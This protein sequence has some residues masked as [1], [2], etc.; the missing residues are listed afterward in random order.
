[1]GSRV[2]TRIITGAL[3]GVA[4]LLLFSA[5]ARTPDFYNA[6][7]GVY[8]EVSREMAA[9]GQLLVPRL[10]SVP[11]LEKPPLVFWMAA[12]S[13]RLL[14]YSP[15]SGR[16]PIAVSGAL[17]VVA[18]YALVVLWE[19]ER[20][21][22]WASISLA[23]SFGYFLYARTLMLEIP[24]T[25]LFIAAMLAFFVAFKRPHYRT[26]MMLSSAALLALAVMVKG[27]IGVAMPA[28]ALCAA[29]LLSRELRAFLKTLPWL[30]MAVVFIAIAVPWHAVVETRVPGAINH[31]LV[32]GQV[33]RYVT[34]N[35]DVTTLA[36][37][38]FVAVSFVWFLPWM[39]FV[40]PAIG[41]A[42]RD[43][44]APVA[45]RELVIGGLAWTAAVIGF[46]VVSPARL[47]YYSVP[48]LAGTAILV[49]RWWSRA[50]FPS[51]GAYRPFIAL[52]GLAIVGLVAT[53][54]VM[55]PAGLHLSF[56]NRVYSLL[57][58]MY[59]LLS[60]RYR[61][62]KSGSESALPIPSARELFPLIVVELTAL[63]AVGLVGL[64]AV[65][66]S[67]RSVAFASVAALAMVTI[68]NVHKG[69]EIM[70][71]LF[72]IAPLAQQ[73]AGLVHDADYVAVTGDFEDLSLISF[74]LR[75]PVLM[76]DGGNGDL[77]F[78]RLSDPITALCFVDYGDLRR[79]WA[80]GRRIF[81]VVN[82]V[83][84]DQPLPEPAY[85]LLQAPTGALYSNRP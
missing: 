34:N 14:G 61:N 3:I 50:A 25:A 42:L 79:L 60:E 59:S 11:Y 63:V 37:L 9:T 17:G 29:A 24:L 44:R 69:L 38:E 74:Y 77:R 39:F 84:D 31:Y 35:Q 27:L 23:T 70:E 41:A 6:D 66:K 21:A 57:S 80:G 76:V 36:A 8:A 54:V 72:S 7:E 53:L 68:F 32:E 85:Q 16:L 47:E 30:P 82:R 43:L 67:A 10:N 15:M 49:G 55:R 4:S 1:M 62:A 58:W 81:V 64:L 48:A 33:V 13:L 22:A 40:P 20:A 26:P 75:R 73:M 78:G 52:L 28:V 45:D 5:A 12:A 19:D 51:P 46:F 71:P 65:R 83:A 56:L 18:L 2:R